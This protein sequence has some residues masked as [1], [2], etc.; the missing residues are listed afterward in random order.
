[1]ELA[2]F[3]EHNYQLELHAYQIIFPNFKYKPPSFISMEIGTNNKVLS[4]TFMI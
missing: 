3:D 2:H 1:M 4:T